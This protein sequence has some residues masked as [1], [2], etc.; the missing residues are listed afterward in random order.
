[1][2][3]F[4][5]PPPGAHK[6]FQTSLILW[7]IKSKHPEPQTRGNLLVLEEGSDMQEAF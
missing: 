3:I 2:P 1:M 6:A 4:L 7:L 5:S